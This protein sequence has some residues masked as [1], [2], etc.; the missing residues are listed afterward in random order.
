MDPALAVFMQAA[1]EAAEEENAG[2]ED[3]GDAEHFE[4]SDEEEVE[5]E[6]E[7]ESDGQSDDPRSEAPQDPPPLVWDADITLLQQM[8]FGWLQHQHGRGHGLFA[9]NFRY[10]IR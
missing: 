6:Q 8:G 1:M 2:A 5:L 3:A 10:F 7:G 9:K 4:M